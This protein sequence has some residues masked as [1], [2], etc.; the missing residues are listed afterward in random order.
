[1]TARELLRADPGMRAGARGAA[2]RGQARAREAT[3][4]ATWDAGLSGSSGFEIPFQITEFSAQSA[5][6]CDGLDSFGPVPVGSPI[7][8]SRTCGGAS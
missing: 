6:F 5:G 2:A 1:M 3:V 7:A 4:G 8:L